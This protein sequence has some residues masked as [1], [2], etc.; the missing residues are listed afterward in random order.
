MTE[1]KALSPEVAKALGELHRFCSVDPSRYNL[2]YVHMVVDKDL[3]TAEATN[4]HMLVRVTAPNLEG[5]LPR[6]E[7]WL[8]REQARDIAKYLRKKDAQLEIRLRGDGRM[9]VVNGS[10]TAFEAIDARWPDTQAIW[11]KPINEEKVEHIGFD[12]DYMSE[13][14]QFARALGV[15][16]N[17]RITFHGLLGPMKLTPGPLDGVTFEALLMPCR[18]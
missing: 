12:A 8:P 4:G 10:V 5:A 7:Y 14:S 13:L 17:Y 11:P 1:E 18:I 6:G 15:Q 16:P 2:C 3:L 9:N